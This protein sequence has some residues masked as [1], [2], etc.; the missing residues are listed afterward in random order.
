MVSIKQLNLQI[1]CRFGL[2]VMAKLRIDCGYSATQLSTTN[3][4]FLTAPHSYQSPFDTRDNGLSSSRKDVGALEQPAPKIQ[5][6]HAVN[7]SPHPHAPESVPS[8]QSAVTQ[9]PSRTSILSST[10]PTSTLPD[11][12]ISLHHAPEQ[13]PQQP[14][15][16]YRIKA[17]SSSGRI[18]KRWSGKKL[19]EYDLPG[20]FSAVAQYTSGR[21]IL[22]IKC[23][24]SSIP[25]GAVHMEDEVG[26]RDEKI[27]EEMSEDF[28]DGIAEGARQGVMTFRL[29]LEPLVGEVEDTE[30]VV[31][32]EGTPG[33]KFLV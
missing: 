12:S 21:E 14:D 27:F 32:S 17:V 20:L 30:T 16:R 22:K 8:N 25:A 28:A 6:E 2:Q 31:K 11:A 3:E 7:Q 24:L 29:L 13:P 15:I 10:P 5:D 26:I 18:Q 4:R 33:R 9:T 23:H 19:S 1:E